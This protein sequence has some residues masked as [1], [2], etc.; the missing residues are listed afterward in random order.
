METLEHTPAASPDDGTLARIDALEILS[1]WEESG[2]FPDRMLGDV[3]PFRRPFVMDLVYTTVRNARALAFAVDSFVRRPPEQRHAYAA[4]LLGAAQILLM[5]DVAQHA[6]VHSTVEALKRLDGPVAAGFVNAVLRNLLRNE[7]AVRASL[8]A[9]PLAVR[10]SH[11]DEQVER[12]TA[13]WGAERAEAICKW[14]NRPASV[15][16]VPLP[17]RPTAPQ[18]LAALLA[19]KVAAT[20]HP[21]LPS[22]A[23]VI[24]HGSHVD[25]LPGFREGLFAIQD[26]ATLE[27]VRLLD[28]R[29]GQRVLD[30]CAAPGGKTVQIAA[31]LAGRGSLLAT[32]CWRDRLRPL[33][34]NLER[35]GFARF[36][37]V[38]VG[39]AKR[40][41]PR[42]VGGEPF[43][44]ILADV[45]CSNTGVQRRRADARWRFEAGR[46]ATL[47]STQL[48]I[49]EN[50]AT[51][52]LAPGGRLVY[53]TCSIEKEENED[54]IEAFLARHPDFRC[55]D[56]VAQVPPDRECD[57]AFAAA[58]ERA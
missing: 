51:R 53:S 48:A 1:R 34:E 37:R 12:W 14:D 38:A 22:A 32:D 11:V 54:V 56:Q 15:T 16:L 2:E 55:V 28:V 8:A 31:R 45:P 57:G 17:G 24:P 30:A 7:P 3:P 26:P 47:A 52:H 33:R 43:D 9:A 13:R 20:R 18:I 39:D 46:L 50:L 19:E 36:V 25:R 44:R 40:I 6:E 4:A 27:A 21:G 35:F 58:I 49:L 23:V 42:D 29:P 41:A 10:E 5:P